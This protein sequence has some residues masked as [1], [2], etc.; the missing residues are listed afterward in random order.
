MAGLFEE[1]CPVKKLPKLPLKTVL[2]CMY[3]MIVVAALILGLAPAVTEDPAVIE[4]AAAAAIL[5]PCVFLG[6]FW[7]CPS[8]GKMLDVRL[9]P[10]VNYCPYCGCDLGLREV[11]EPVSKRRESGEEKEEH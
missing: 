2:T 5:I 3:G 1:V 11:N 4:L 9:S 8:C 10:K 6:L 7:R